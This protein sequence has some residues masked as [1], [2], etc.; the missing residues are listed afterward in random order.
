[1][2]QRLVL[3]PSAFSPV[4]GTA[5]WE[6]LLGAR[7]IETGRFVIAAAQTG[8]QKTTSGKARQTYGHS[9]VVSP[10]GEFWSMQAS[11]ATSR[12]LI[13]ILWQCLKPAVA[14]PR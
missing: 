6:P 7:A 12:S 10:W 5:H 13:L 1:M 11:V 8:T 4:T 9:L 2:P 3:V 14:F